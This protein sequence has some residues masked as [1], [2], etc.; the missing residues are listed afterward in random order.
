MKKNLDESKGLWVEYLHEILW[1]YHTTLHSTTKETPFRM[2][3]ET[4]AMIQVEV[5]TST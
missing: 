3:Y 4:N 2:V 1:S 5:N